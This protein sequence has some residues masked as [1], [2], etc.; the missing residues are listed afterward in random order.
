MV[1]NIMI[2]MTTEV[3]LVMNIIIFMTTADLYGHEYH[4]IHDHTR[5][6][7]GLAFSAEVL[8]SHEYEITQHCYSHEH[9]HIYVI[10]MTTRVSAS[11]LPPRQGYGIV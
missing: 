1:M 10:Y 5:A 7:L 9:H 11:G 2:F 6:C 3:L 8:C 4:Y